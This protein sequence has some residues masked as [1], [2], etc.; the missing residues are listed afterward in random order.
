MKHKILFFIVTICLSCSSFLLFSQKIDIDKD[1]NVKKGNKVLVKK[2]E[3]V[4]YRYALDNYLITYKTY[5]NDAQLNLKI[6]DC[7]YGLF[8]DDLA[9]K[10]GNKAYELD[11]TI[12]PK[13]TF[14]KGI[15]H[16]VQDQF[17]EALKYFKYFEAM[18]ISLSE[19]VE[20]A[21][22]IAQ[23][24]KALQ[25]KTN[26]IFCFIDNLGEKVNT[27]YH[28]YAPVFVYPSSSSLL[29][30]TSKKLDKKVRYGQDGGFCE[31]SF[32]A[33][34]RDEV[35]YQSNK[36]KNT[37]NKKFNAIQCISNDGKK[38]II[39][40]EKN[41]GDLGEAQLINGKIASVKMF[42]KTV[43]SPT[44]HESTACYSPSGDT[45][46]YAS[47]RNG[48]G[49]YGGHDLYYIYRMAKGVKG[50]KGGWSKPKN[51]GPQINSSQDELSVSISPDGSTLYFSSLGHNGFG[52]FDIYK[53]VKENGVFGKPEN[54]G[55]PINTSGDEMYYIPTPDN[56][57]AYYASTRWG[58]LGGLDIFKIIYI[59]PKE[60][61]YS[62]T[63]SP[64]PIPSLALYSIERVKV[65]ERATTIVGTVRDAATKEP[66]QAAVELF[67][68][69][70]QELLTTFESDSITGS[71]L[72]SLPS[73][74]N[75]AIQVKKIGYLLQSL[76]FNIPDDADKATIEQTILLDK[77]AVNKSI[78]LRNIF[79]DTGKA[80]LRPE[81][82][83][84]INTLF[85]LLVDNP[86]MYIEI[87]GHTD[88]VG[89]A[90]SN[91]KLSQNRAKAVLDNL[92]TKGIASSRLKCEGYGFSKPIATNKTAEG[93]Q[94]NRRTEFKVLKI[95]H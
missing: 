93:R 70:N 52:G 34:I 91:K 42:P 27:P 60:Y 69:D 74:C 43:N 3:N 33:K 48:I 25:M 12:S 46:Y 81:S 57:I 54:L 95:V 28:D 63:I 38:A 86:D 37:L 87:S 2:V 82:E 24:E 20:V 92:V 19:K 78:V 76:N 61:A 94:E 5:S 50:G 15:Y 55:Y 83:V 21:K 62:T 72:L 36:D 6:A 31:Q 47:N 77:I 23:T 26:K 79:F 89:S 4:K 1:K 29:Y 80:T 73:G 39:Y 49:G 22:R 8:Y 45:V 40:S 7:Y 14:Y 66:L 16:Q 53:S 9:A 32:I 18:P 35:P 10:Y 71:Y 11:P 88:N 58:T 17:E 51:L 56:K 85:K 64:H 13:V 68:L 59:E 90:A 30:Y 75:Y 44:S 67:S 84:E 41:A 65:D